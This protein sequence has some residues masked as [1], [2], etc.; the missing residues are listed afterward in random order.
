MQVKLPGEK[1]YSDATLRT[2][3]SPYAVRLRLADGTMVW[4]ALSRLRVAT[5]G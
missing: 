3:L 5:G 2:L 4:T 1:R